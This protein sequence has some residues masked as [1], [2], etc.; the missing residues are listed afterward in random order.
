MVAF[1]IAS[2]HWWRISSYVLEADP[3][4]SRPCLDAAERCIKLSNAKIKKGDPTGEGHL[5]LGGALGL[6]GRWEATNQKWID[7]Y[8]SGKKAYKYLSEALKINPSLTDA[9]IGH[10]IF[11]YFVATLPAIIRSL[12]FVGMGN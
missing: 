5:V 1:G 6:R 9:Y 2:A 4:E 7:A 11:D 3:K 10:G 8:F 12:A